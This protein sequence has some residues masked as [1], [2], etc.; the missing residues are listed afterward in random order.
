MQLYL[1]FVLVL[2][3]ASVIQVAYLEPK[4]WKEKVHWF[5]QGGNF[6][7]AEF[8]KLKKCMK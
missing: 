4:S 2:I 8:Y 6:K 1:F 7:S 5:I 3:C